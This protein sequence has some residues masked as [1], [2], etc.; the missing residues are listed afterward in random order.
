[1]IPAKARAAALQ[2][3]LDEKKPLPA[4][5]RLLALREALGLTQTKL[6]EHLG[7]SCPAVGSW[8]AAEKTPS[9]EN[10]LLLERWSE[11]AARRLNVPLDQAILRAQ[12]W[13]TDEEKA[14]VDA[15]EP[16]RACAQ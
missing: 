7:A 16:E 4:P 6:G 1:M 8:E 9:G 15:F 3:L 12:D 5:Q 14:R 11:A 13:L 10:P 2:R